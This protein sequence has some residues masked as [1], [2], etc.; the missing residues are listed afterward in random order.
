MLIHLVG[1]LGGIP[2]VLMSY[3]TAPFVKR[4]S[5]SI[6]PYAQLT[7]ANLQRFAATMG[8]TTCLEFTTLRAYPIQR[9]STL[10]LQELRALPTQRTRFANIERVKTEATVKRWK[11]M[12]WY[13]KMLEIANEPRWKFYV[14]E[15]RSYTIPT[16]VPGVWEEV[17]K[18]IQRQTENLA[19]ANGEAVEKAEKLI[20]EPR[21]KVVK[22]QTAR[23]QR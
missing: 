22:R 5:L 17:A 8:P 1:I 20:Q 14:K 19:R 2:L 7:R 9:T 6:P 3:L 4:I 11:E 13:R 12:S 21:R 10:L 23:S 15:G 16:G 18:T